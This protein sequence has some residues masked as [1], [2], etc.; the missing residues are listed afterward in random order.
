MKNLTI[1]F[2]LITLLFSVVPAWRACAKSQNGQTGLIVQ[3]RNTMGGGPREIVILNSGYG[4]ITN[5]WFSVSVSPGPVYHFWND[6]TKVYSEY[7]KL[8]LKTIASFHSLSNRMNHDVELSPSTNDNLRRTR[9]ARLVGKGKYL[10]HAVEKY[11][12]HYKG[13]DRKHHLVEVWT[14]REVDGKSPILRLYNSLFT[15]FYP[16]GYP[17]LVEA[18]SYNSKGQKKTM[19]FSKVV[20]MERI[21][22]DTSNFFFDKRKY[23]KVT[24]LYTVMMGSQRSE[25]ELLFKERM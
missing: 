9:K 12:T 2:V 1:L 7:K 3:E 18:V 25:L 8:P 19:N 5:N 6:E 10:G 15:N 13:M 20:K 4:K 24:D 17:V 11:L 21:K 14:L 16:Q 22:R 23:E